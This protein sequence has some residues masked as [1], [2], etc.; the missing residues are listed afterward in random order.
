M[1][2]R[3]SADMK[4]SVNLKHGFANMKR[5]FAGVI[6][7]TVLI[8]A[9]G[10][11]KVRLTT[12][13]TRS[14]FARIDGVVVDMDVAG[15]L[16]SEYKYSY[17]QL[18]DSQVWNKSMGEITTEEYVKNKTASTLKNIILAGN[19]SKEL[20][21]ALTEDENARI[22]KAAQ[23]YM[24]SLSDEAAGEISQDTVEQ[25]YYYLLLADKGF[26]GVTDSVDTKVSTDEARRIYVQYIFFGTTE[27]DEEHNIV[28]VSKGEQLVK[29]DTAESVLKKA[30]EGEDF[31]ALAGE[32]SDDIRNSME[33]GQGEADKAFEEAAY[34]LDSGGIS[35]V[36]ETE[37][38]YYIIKCINY[39]VES[40]YAEQSER[41]VLARRR[42]LYSEQF[43]EYA[44]NKSVEFNDRFWENIAIKDLSS[45]S[46]RLYEIY[47]EYFY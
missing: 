47:S 31:L 38:G 33:L 40:D 28:P 39:N 14:Q 32:Y 24:G 10:C 2:R 25:F 9:G 17:E 46:G 41:V 22:G 16:L 19:M 44:N 21:I 37:Y 42:D 34:M 7:L 11:G 13:L 29:K 18:F 27:Y 43:L 12:G 36:V 3:N 23:D 1:L 6:L 30:M 26:Y 8:C 4:K 15:L 45:G 20:R 5:W 35:Q